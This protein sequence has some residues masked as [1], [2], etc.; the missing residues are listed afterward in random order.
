MKIVKDDLEKEKAI[1]QEL[2]NFR[3]NFYYG[4]ESEAFWQSIINESD[5]I[6]RK[7]NSLYVDNMLLVCVEDIEARLHKS[8]NRPVDELEHFQHI[9]HVLERDRKKEG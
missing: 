9:V 3:K 4:E 8:Q 1:Q 6:S 2:W 5:T 7:Y